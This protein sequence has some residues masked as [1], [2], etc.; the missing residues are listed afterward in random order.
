MKM[1]DQINKCPSHDTW[2]KVGKFGL[3]ASQMGPIKDLKKYCDLAGIKLPSS[4]DFDNVDYF[5][6]SITHEETHRFEQSGYVD[7]LTAG[8]NIG[9]PPVF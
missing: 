9:L 2:K 8:L 5:T 6:E 4:V 1:F 3:V 7:G